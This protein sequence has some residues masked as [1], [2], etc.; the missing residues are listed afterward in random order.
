MS[1]VRQTSPGSHVTVLTSALVYLV[2]NDTATSLTNVNNN[3]G[4]A[5]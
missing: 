4:E 1:D 3:K 2:L 5:K